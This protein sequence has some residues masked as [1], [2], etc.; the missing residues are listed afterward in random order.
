MAKSAFPKRAQ[1][2]YSG[3]KPKSKWDEFKW[4]IGATVVALGIFMAF[5]LRAPLQSTKPSS[6][7]GS[8]TSKEATAPEGKPNPGIKGINNRPAD[9]YV[10]NS[11]G[12]I[13]APYL[14][15]PVPVYS[16]KETSTPSPSVPSSARGQYRQGGGF[17]GSASP[18]GAPG[19]DSIASSQRSNA[20]S[21]GRRQLNFMMRPRMT[22]D[23]LDRVVKGG[24]VVIKVYVPPLS[25]IATEARRLVA[26][27]TDPKVKGMPPLYYI[28]IGSSF[29]AGKDATNP[30][31][32]EF[33]P[34]THIS[35]PGRKI[36]F[37]GL[38]AFGALKDSINKAR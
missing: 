23:E 4:Y 16:D 2:E 5:Y 18:N 28:S 31:T 33:W 37:K 27:I 29:E 34:L 9:Q 12:Q 13:E 32:A 30:P 11:R 22:N 25:G 10:R 3:Q 24:G 1:Y 7:A 26:A 14:Q 17:S 35:G 36:Q 6:G 8:K 19:S 15:P 21:A 20:G 38:A